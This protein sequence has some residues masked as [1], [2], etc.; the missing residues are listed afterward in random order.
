MLAHHCVTPSMQINY[1]REIPTWSLVSVIA[2]NNS[3]L[4]AFC[5]CF[6]DEESAMQMMRFM[7]ATKWFIT[8][9]LSRLF[10]FADICNQRAW[11]FKLIQEARMQINRKTFPQKIRHSNLLFQSSMF[12]LYTAFNYPLIA[13]INLLQIINNFHN[14]VLLDFNHPTMCIQLF[15]Y[16]FYLLYYL[17][18]C[19]CVFLQLIL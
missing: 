4:Y 14:F 18:Y 15:L 10:I 13:W 8:K 3:E 1:M 11:N 2:V 5:L 12:I 9:Q 19:L 6:F 7:M 17:V 16:S